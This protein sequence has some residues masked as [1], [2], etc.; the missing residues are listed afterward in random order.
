MEETDEER[1]ERLK[2]S[3]EKRLL[4]SPVPNKKIKFFPWG[5]KLK[6]LKSKL[7][8]LLPEALKPTKYVPPKPAE[9]TEPVE[10]VPLPKLNHILN[11]YPKPVNE[12]VQ[13][14]IDKI[15]PFYKKEAIEKFQKVLSDRRSLRKI[16]KEKDRALKN[17]AKSFEVTIIESRDPDKQLYYTTPNVLGVLKG[18]IIEEKGF[19]FYLTLHI[20]FKKL[21]IVDGREVFE[22]KDAYFNSK[23]S[24]I[25]NGDQIPD[26]LEV[27]REVLINKIAEWLSEG[28]DWTVEAIDSHYVNIVKYL[29]LRGS[30][31]IPLPEELRNPKIGL[32]NPKNEDQK[33]FLWCHV[34]HLNPRKKDPQR[35]KLSDR[36][37]VKRLDYNGIT[38]PVTINQIPQ[39]EK[40]NKININLF[41]YH[42]KRTF[43][44][45]ISTEKYGDHMELLYIESN[46]KQH[47]VYIK[48]FNSLMY[49]FTKHKGSKHFCMHCLK[50]VYSIEDL[51]KHRKDCIVVNG[52]QAVE[53][54]EPYIDRHGQERIPSG[55]FNNY[56]K[57]LPV[58][59]VIYDDFDSITEK[60]STC[61]PSDENSYTEK[62][63][64]HTACS[65]GY[66]VV[67]HHDKKYS[68]DVVIYRGS[69]PVG[70]FLKC[71]NREVQNC[72]KVIG[73][74]F[75][76][77]LKMSREDEINFRK[78]THCHICQKKYRLNDES[79]AQVTGH[80]PV[81]DHCHVT[82]KYRG[83]A[84]KK[85]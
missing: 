59:F 42:K 70:E 84:H 53:L 77:P 12:E 48:D 6:L 21:K 43:P 68:K 44:I 83:S 34:R 7:I 32:I 56:H 5:N 82:G 35:I 78:A 18:L 16:V 4:D 24:T 62:Y 25:T 85:M 46:E 2:R 57:Q 67:C 10:P 79:S 75:N 23:A 73:E 41:G 52:V 29:P 60:M 39:I 15:T 8:K 50:N 33:C 1:L 51:A 13:K 61:T 63:Q 54:T 11:Q 72:Q 45:R 26:S 66:K 38:F 58:P 64:K 69:D 14:Y 27:A 55:Y 71:M 30:S 37:F 65:F 20:M 19:K 36:E 76:K 17:H 40:Q 31:Y 22:F 28:S 9:P 74:N 49:N 80:K 81:R 3:F 47:Y